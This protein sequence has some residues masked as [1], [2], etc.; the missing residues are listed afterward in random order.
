M[1]VL[2]LKQ[3]IPLILILF[4]IFQTTRKAGRTFAAGLDTPKIVI[5]EFHGLKKNIIQD[6]LAS[7][8]HFRDVIQGSGGEQ[9]WIH[10][11][12]VYHHTRRIRT[13]LYVHVYRSAPSEYRCGI[14]HMV[15][16]QIHES[17]HHDFLW[18]TAHQSHPG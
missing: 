4:L 10:L 5:I 18:S 13:R 3:I 1:C 12:N 6:N 7:L 15:R 2:N 11:S 8:P 14:H 16:P 9:N 17:T